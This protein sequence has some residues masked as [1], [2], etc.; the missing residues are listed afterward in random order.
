MVSSILCLDLQPQS[1]SQGC[2]GRKQDLFEA[3]IVR[4]ALGLFLASLVLFNCELTFLSRTCLNLCRR[5]GTVRLVVF[6]VSNRHGRA[7]AS[8][9][10]LQRLFDSEGITVVAQAPPDQSPPLKGASCALDWKNPSGSAAVRSQN[11]WMCMSSCFGSS[12]ATRV[13]CLQTTQADLDTPS[14]LDWNGRHSNLVT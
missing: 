8:K 6:A 1:T 2:T 13:F 10:D 5:Q 9:V 7:G 14:D 11:M 4:Y 3:C 12:C